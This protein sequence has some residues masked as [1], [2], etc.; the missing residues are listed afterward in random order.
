MAAFEP[1]PSQKEAV[2]AVGGPLLVSAGAGSGKTRVLTERL[3]RF[4]K[5]PEHPVSIT[6]F[7]VITFTQAAAAELRGRITDELSCAIGEASCREVPDSALLEHLRRQQALCGKAQI[8]TIHAFCSSLLRENGHLLS[9]PADF[10]I[11]SDERAAALKA[12]A[13]DQVLEERYQ[14]L[15]GHAGFEALVN[16]VGIGRDDARLS[17]LT[18]QLYEKMQCHSHPER[19]AQKCVDALS[20]ETPDVGTTLWGKEILSQCLASAR[21][22]A[23]EL[24]RVIA[25]VSEDAVI[26][27]A[28]QP[29]LRQSA[30]DIHTLAD[31]LEHGW[32]A[33]RACPPVRFIKFNGVR[34]D[35]DASLK[36]YVKKRRDPCKDAMKKIA[37]RLYADSAALTGELRQSAPAMEALLKLTLDFEHRYTEL[38]RSAGRLDY[39]DLEHLTAKLLLHEDGT[40]TDLARAIASRYE[41]IM[42]DEYQ[43][44][45]RVQDDIFHALSR[46]GR[47]LFFVGDVKQAIYRFRLADPE[48]FNEKFREYP[49][50]AQAAPGSAGKI[51]LRENFRSRREILNAANS[52]FSR[53]MTPQLGEIS[54]DDSAALVFGATGYEGSVPLP[55]IRLFPL[56]V[57]EAGQPAA[58]KTAFEADCV[59]RM[60]EELV[61]SGAQVHCSSGT[62]PV[63]YGDIAILLRSANIAGGAYRRALTAHAIPVVSGQGG[64]LFETREASFVLSFLHVMDNP[65]GDVSL[66]AV[67]SSPVFRFTAD[68][69]AAIRTGSDALCFYDA[70]KA[71]ARTDGKTR[72][73]LETLNALRDVAP[74]LPLKK[75]L[76]KIY[77]DTDLL[78]ICSAMPDGQNRCANLMQLIRLAEKYEDEG[79][80]GLHAFVR[81]L[82]TL[83]EKKMG[84]PSAVGDASAVQILSIHRSKG[85]EFPV[86][87]LCDTARKFN[88]QDARDTVLVHPEL[89][90][91]PKLVDN[92]LLCQRPTFARQAIAMRIRKESLSEEM[93][94][95]YVALTRAEERL[96]I[97]A[98]LPDPD[99]FLAKTGALLPRGDEEIDPEALSGAAS[100]IE[101]FA[102]AALA[103]GG[104]HLRLVC[105]VPDLPSESRD[106]VLQT[107]EEESDTQQWLEVLKKNLSFSYPY[108]EASLLPSK[109]TA[110]ELKHAR[111]A[112]ENEESAPLLPA[113]KEKHFFR[114]PDLS[115]DQRPLTAAERG[116]ATHLAL[117]YMDPGK[118][119]TAEG[120]RQEIRRL[121]EQRFLS[122]RQAEAVR[123]EAIVRLFRSEI[124]QQLQQ[125]ETV[126]RE[127]RF[128][129]LCTAEELFSVPSREEILLQG[130]VDCCIETPEDLV[131]IDYKTDH[132]FTEEQISERCALYASQLRA[133]ALALSRI[134]EKPV[135]QCVLYFLSCGRCVKLQQGPS[136]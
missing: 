35:Y 18:L 94:L 102:A 61:A 121:A 23:S 116:I 42:V 110:T 120:V 28:Y 133:Y 16:S 58:D 95:Q 132:V 96:F 98:A 88:L 77:T 129:I 33:A 82:D 45:S 99:A 93:R 41:E 79:V 37:S 131:I 105:S 15:P 86:V 72:H 63:R 89:G 81:H 38:K 125:A 26:C 7:V 76:W 30:D 134:F 64:G 60:I 112:A 73:F 83:K 122:P 90:L 20:A 109:V 1:T 2:E 103:D 62:R 19:W 115:G 47:N 78:A 53:C 84:V 136:A 8:G 123:Q 4:L 52:V 117:Q 71:A 27:K 108:A 100:P 34:G 127:F 25:A 9:L 36:E 119:G 10:Q 65:R 11:L 126:H 17:E 54:Y 32:E 97:T 87:F 55:E 57:P 70:V 118:G 106:A 31:A 91:G 24:E 29:S 51:L 46:D 43:D 92:T 44:V 14:D 124:G 80:F 128:S 21:Y 3:M 66:I 104:E 12:E 113:G 56:P 5:D 22:W 48:I 49:L 107:P 75:L 59:A 6:R 69:L 39:S 40:P 13:L 50:H 85:L 68:D 74:D 101:W 111:P 135:R 114:L 67:L 130:V